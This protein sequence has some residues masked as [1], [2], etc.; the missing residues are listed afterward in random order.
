MHDGGGNRQQTVDAL[1]AIIKAYKKAGY[2]F[3]TLDE[4]AQCLGKR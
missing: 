3:V 2:H 1:P 4:Y